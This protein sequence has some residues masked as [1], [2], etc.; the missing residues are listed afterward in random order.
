MNPYSFMI[1]L[2]AKHPKEDLAFMDRLFAKR[3]QASWVA[4]EERI[5]PRGTSIGGKRSNS[6]WVSRLTEEEIH[7]DTWQ[8][9][10]YLEKTYKEVIP[11]IESLEAF[12]DSGGRLELYVSLYGSRNYGLVL[13]PG[14]LARLGAAGI[15]LQLDIHPEK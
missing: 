6:Y 1:S 8:L 11:K 3:P 5:T 13:N 4:G 9:E 15:E 14:L 2:R 10:D 7:S 12:L